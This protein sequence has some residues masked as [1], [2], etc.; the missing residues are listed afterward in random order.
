MAR[1]LPAAALQD[2]LRATLPATLLILLAACGEAPTA[3]AQ[4][5]AAEQDDGGAK[6]AAASQAESGAAGMA[7]LQSPAPEG[8]M[9]YII[10]PEDG[11]TVTSPLR[12]LFGLRG[13][14]VAPAGH[15]AKHSGHH[16]LLIDEPEYVLEQPLPAT[17]QI[18]HFGAGQTETQIELEPGEHK[19]QLLLGNHLHVPHTPPVMSEII[20]VTV[21]AED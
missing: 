1:F 5:S 16:H 18:V 19:L 17:E 7:A 14:G 21:V 3:N 9:A 8:A 13:M 10:Q 4:A 20:T 12:V 2:R 11:A 15:D 6:A